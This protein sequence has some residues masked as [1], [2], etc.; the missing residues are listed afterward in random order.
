MVEIMIP[1][2]RLTAEMVKKKFK[3]GHVNAKG[4]RTEKFNEEDKWVIPV[5]FN[6]EG[7]ASEIDYIPNKTM[8]KELLKA[9]G[10]ESDSWDGLKINFST[11]KV[12]FQGSLV[13]SI[14]VEPEVAKKL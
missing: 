13:D 11:M 2:S 9:W 6:I 8:L 12:N 14:A 5:V 4:I 3:E 10:S 7:E 1:S